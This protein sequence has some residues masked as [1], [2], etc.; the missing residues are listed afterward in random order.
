[1]AYE[2]DNSWMQQQ[3]EEEEQ[4][5]L[6]EERNRIYALACQH[7]TKADQ[8][9]LAFFML[10]EKQMIIVREEAGKDFQIAPQG[11]QIGRAHV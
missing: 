5:W 1:M 3:Q 8:E 10:Q 6:E 4:Q 11:N 7:L 9:M 2:D